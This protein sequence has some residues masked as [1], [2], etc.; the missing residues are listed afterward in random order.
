ME[1]TVRDIM[2]A[3]ARVAGPSDKLVDAFH[4]MRL[5]GF[6]HMPVVED[7]KL[8]GIVSDHDIFLGWG[9]GGDTPV[10]ELMTKSPRWVGPDANARDAAALLLRHKI[11]CLP[12]I[13]DGRVV[14]IVTQA[15][16]VA[17]AHRELL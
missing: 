6:R 4:V 12:V 8:V 2:T 3:K 5:A 1:R 10:G 17:F 11:G 16:F 9:R 7:G 14:G 13:D 15:D